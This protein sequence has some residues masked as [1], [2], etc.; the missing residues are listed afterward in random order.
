MVFVLKLAYV[1]VLYVNFAATD[2][3]HNVKKSKSRDVI[4]VK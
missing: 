1:A 2:E 4:E 3:P